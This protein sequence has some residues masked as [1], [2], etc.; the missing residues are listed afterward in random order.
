MKRK[1]ERV[2]ESERVERQVGQC[3]DRTLMLGIVKVKCVTVL[4]RFVSRIVAN[5]MVISII[6]FVS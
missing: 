3:G 4:L 2:R 6:E 1:R 5:K